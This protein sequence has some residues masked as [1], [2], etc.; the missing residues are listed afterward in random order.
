MYVGIAGL[1]ILAHN[2]SKTPARWAEIGHEEEK[3]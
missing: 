1:W 2:H 3:T